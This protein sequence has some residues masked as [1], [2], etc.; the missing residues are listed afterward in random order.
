MRQLRLVPSGVQAWH[1]DTIA[2]SNDVFAYSSTMALHIFRLKD[3]SLQKMIA[4][5]ERAITAI[6]W[7]PDDS[8]LLASCSVSGRVAIWDLD[9]E[10]ERCGTKVDSPP[11]LM[12]WAPAG[13]RIALALDSGEIRLWE[14]R[15]ADK[16]T[17]LFSLDKAV[18]AKVLRFHPRVATKM[19]VGDSVGSLHIYDQQANKRVQIVGKAK[20]S[21]DPVTDAQ[22]DP[23]SEEYLLVAFGDGSLTLFDASTQREVHSFDKQPQGIKSLAWARAQP[24]NFVTSTDRVGVLRLWNVSQR[25]PLT[26]IKVGPAGVNCIKAIPN[27]PNWFVLS[28]KNSAVGVCDIAARTIKFMST[29]GHS[30]TIFDV[31]FHPDDPDMLATASYDG[32]VKLWRISTT[33]SHREMFAGK[34]QLLY[35]LAFGPGATRICAV[36]STGALFIWRAD[37]GEQ[38]FRLSVHSGQAYRCEWNQRGRAEGTGEIATGGAD[39]FACITD[40]ATGNI[41]RRITHPDAVVGVVWHP[42]QDGVLATACADAVVRI[43]NLAASHARDGEPPPIAILQGHSARAFNL[44]FHPICPNIIAS[45]SDDK[46]IRVWNWSPNAHRELRRLMGHSAYVRGLLWHSELPHILFSGSWDATIRVWDVAA[47]R[48]LHV[49]YEHHADVYGLALHPRRPF[50]LA[51][52]SRDTTLRFWIFEDEVRPLLVQALVRPARFAELLGAGPEE[53]EALLHSIPGNAPNVP[54]RLYGQE[55]C[56][57]AASLA[58]LCQQSPVSLQVY[59]KIISF[60]LYRAGMEDLWGLLATARGERLPS[61]TSSRTVFHEQELIQCQKSKALEMASQRA[62]IGIGG[63]YEERLLKAAQIMLRVGDLR[64]YCRFTAQAG[65]WER[66]ICIAPAVSQEFWQQLCGEY[67]DTLSATTDLEEAAPFW[68]ATGRSSRLV[69]SYIERSELDNAFVVAKAECDGLLPGASPAAPATAPSPTSGA[70]GRTRLQDVASVLSRRYA[71]MGEPLQAAMVFLAVSDTQ[72]A[73]NTLS[74]AHEAVM[75]YVVASL[76]GQPQD[77]IVLRLMAL[78]AERDGRWD[79]AAEVWQNHPQ[80]Q[81]LHLPLLAARAPDKQAAKAW[82]PWTPEQYKAQLA[83]AQGA[84]AVV[85]AVCAGEHDRAAQLGIESLHALFGTPG[86]TVEQARSFLDPLEALPLQDMKVKDIAGILACAAYVGLV[87]ANALAYHELMFPLAQT[88]RNIVTHQSLPF[89]VSMAEVAIMEAGCTS[90]RNRDYSLRQLSGLLQAP[91]LPAHSRQACEQ[92]IAEIQRRPANAEPPAEGLAKIAGG[93]L[94]TCYKRYSKTSVLTNQ[95]IRGPAFELEDHQSY[96]A[97]VDAL[98]WARVNRFSPLNTGCKVM[99]V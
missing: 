97:L 70:V 40:A 1:R 64:S 79:V 14:Y 11:M 45:G 17:K 99:P 98:A 93:Q 38:L 30:E 72:R 31:V 95:L 29:P 7:S 91:D 53:A 49:A 68:V 15:E 69:D 76:L 47:Q 83:E 13:D 32:H 88:L 90:W 25:A 44:A 84:T 33:E 63:K 92:L 60:F 55:S 80:G 75:A 89:P 57:L 3:M 51:S 87:E 5:H 78:C 46:T 61:G 28:F 96:I 20:T 35:G 9:N 10:E 16:Q 12:D 62:S 66:A 58:Q 59:Q 23:L 4:A 71:A 6:C 24:G 18:S 21:K 26:Q 43:F 94:P 41:V 48:C 74:R 42:T 85:A 86:W 56:Q 37:T 27:Q 2:A 19:L 67:I 34:D 65:Q 8:N 36:S 54:V 73:V 52:S 81:A 39:H 77:P 50:F 82:C 22:W